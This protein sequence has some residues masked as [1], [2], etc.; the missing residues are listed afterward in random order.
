MTDA[1]SLNKCPMEMQS[2]M[3][4]NQTCLP[5]TDNNFCYTSITNNCCTVKTFD[6]S[7]KDNY[8]SSTNNLTNTI[9]L[10]TI[11]AVPSISNNLNF[12]G[13]LNRIY[14]DSSPPL[15]SSNSLYLTNSTLLI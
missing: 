13:N 5:E 4:D 14:F 3:T 6:S 15:L 7:I 12:A 10:L 11:I 1:Y 9:Q 8:I 2:E